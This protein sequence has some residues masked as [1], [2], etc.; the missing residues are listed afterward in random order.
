[1]G[2]RVLDRG[3]GSLLDFDADLDGFDLDGFDLDGFD[4]DF[5]A[6]L[7]GLDL[8][9]LDLDLDLEWD[10]E[11]ED[12]EGAWS[13]GSKWTSKGGGWLRWAYF[14]VQDRAVV[15]NFGLLLTKTRAMAGVR[16]SSGFGSVRRDEME[17]MRAVMVR[18][19]D[20]AL[21]RRSRQIPPFASMLGW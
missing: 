11:V 19:G 12:L 13:G 14:L 4:L 17:S 21:L 18:A 10:L 8:D 1:L 16:G 7:D 20:Q 9:G 6:D 3:A 2:L 15:S 5:D